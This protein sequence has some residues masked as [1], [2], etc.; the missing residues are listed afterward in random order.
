VFTATDKESLKD[1]LLNVMN[2]KTL[3]EA[4]I[5][6]ISK[7]GKGLSS[8]EMTAISAKALQEFEAAKKAL[9]EAKLAYIDGYVNGKVLSDDMVELLGKLSGEEKALINAEAKAAKEALDKLAEES[10][11]AIEKAL[12]EE[13]AINAAKVAAFDDALQKKWKAYKPQIKG[14][15]VK[16]LDL[17]PAEKKILGDVP[18][19]EYDDLMNKVDATMS[20]K[21][22]TA[23]AGP[24]VPPPAPTT[25]SLDDF[26]KVGG[27]LGSNEGGTYVNKVTGEQFYIKLSASNDI[28]QNE[29]MATHLYKMAGVNATDMQLIDLGN[30]K[31]GVAS[32][33][34][35]GL[36][37]NPGAL[38]SGKLAGVYDGFGVDAWLAN[39]DV[40]GQTYNNMKVLNGVTAVRVD[41]GGALFYRA[42]GG[43]KTLGNVVEE[44]KSLRDASINSQSATVFA[45]MK[46]ADLEAAIRR[47]LNIKESDIAA[48]VHGYGDLW[49]VS[50]RRELV[51]TLIARQRYIAQQFPDLVEKTVEMMGKAVVSQDQF[52]AIRAARGN[53]VA[54]RVDYKQ[55]EDQQIL[56]HQE[57]F[58]N[59]NDG[60]VGTF[61]VRAEGAKIM[62][63]YVA[64]AGGLQ[65]GPTLEY[66]IKG[67]T[68]TDIDGVSNSII[69][70]LKGV[71]AQAK[72]GE[73]L[74]AKDID[75][76][77]AAVAK[78][79]DFWDKASLAGTNLVGSEWDL[80]HRDWNGLLGK[81]IKA[82][83]GAP[84][85]DFVPTKQFKAFEVP[86]ITIPAPKLPESSEIK[87]FKKAGTFEKAT[88]DKG[89]II[90][91]NIQESLSVGGENYFYEAEING[92][93]VRYWPKGDDSIA[94][95]LQ[96]RVQIIT[97]G[98]SK[99]AINKAISALDKIG[100]NVEIPA[101]IQKEEM[102]LQK[103]A[104]HLNNSDYS[105]RAASI[106][107]ESDVTV[108]ITR[109][110]EYLN[111][112]LGIKD[113]TTLPDYKPDGTLEHFNQGNILLHRPDLQGPAWDAFTKEY[114]LHHSF[115]SGDYVGGFDRI[116]DSG[117]KLA[118]STD[119]VRRGI[120]WGTSSASTDFKY[121]GADYVYTRVKTLSSSKSE[122]GI[123]W[124]ADNHLRRL[125]AI[126]YSGDT[127]GQTKATNPVGRGGTPDAALGEDG[128]V[129]TNRAASN[130][131]GWKNMAQQHSSNETIFKGGLSIF[132][133]VEQ[134]K[135]PREQY[136]KVLAIF[137]KH[138][139]TEWPDGRALTD[140]IVK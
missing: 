45:G 37:V 23:V 28:A 44:L 113:I 70:T 108:R 121:G 46:Q 41:P 21:T 74:R 35:D 97:D 65:P 68:K 127:Y 66:A 104:Y 139:I 130:I 2:S 119:R 76:A 20:S 39:W 29:V 105:V 87:F 72:N 106:G 129:L 52:W 137:R 1:A 42:Q 115:W 112:K 103:I 16:G 122:A 26:K 31:W 102:Y 125:D 10:A 32:R 12:A 25:L 93:K 92:V 96:G 6:I 116:L 134:I 94:Y 24:S 59:G 95:S 123:T 36:E 98:A 82:G 83:E 60:I 84:A 128:F 58:S 132:E 114:R 43:T 75:R 40:V 14:K 48:T 131:K 89:N 57:R 120:P 33:W 17:T 124:R 5:A 135:V 54:V 86:S 88:I 90:R 7:A 22:G 55:L 78:L 27:K 107:N 118:A 53:G 69:D 136:D 34:I 18:K 8:D 11:L 62:D 133:D 80:Y 101:L 71:G 77:K 81:I 15:L 111:T 99:E 49:S 63:G 56:F 91:S 138:K 117:G 30:G 61:K 50:Q 110:K 79:S 19:H 109:W 4:D 85:K 67:I 51:D 9:D 126:S 13:A 100:L 47:V 64:R 140:V 73:S 38:Q 3:S